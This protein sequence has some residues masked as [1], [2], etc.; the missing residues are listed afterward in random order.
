[1]AETLTTFMAGE[2]RLTSSVN[3]T[4]TDSHSVGGRTV[5]IP[6]GYY[7][8]RLADSSADGSQSNPYDLLARLQT[9]ANAAPAAGYWSFELTAQG[10][11]RITYN[12]GSGT[13]SITWDGSGIVRDV[14]GFT[15]GVSFGG[16]GV[17]QTATYHPTHCLF[18]ICRAGDTG[19]QPVPPMM[20]VCEL[21]DGSV[22]GEQD[23]NEN[24]LRSFDL[25]FHPK[26]WATRT[27]LGAAGTPMLPV[28]SRWKVPSTGA[29]TDPPWS[30]KDFVRAAAFKA[31]GVCFDFQALTTGS[32]FDECYLAESALR[33]DRAMVQTIGGIDQR[34]DFKGFALR[35]YAERTSA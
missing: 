1:M 13:A 18:S 26:D 7:R 17:A 9:L 33:A 20:A 21:P 5:T 23:A 6:A 24:M 14:L 11:V 3:L 31:V 22:V 34:Y 16:T 19:W 29:G 4:V 25:R 15:A 12:G 27:S 32:K 10:F 2:I 8:I 28:K 30:V 35:F